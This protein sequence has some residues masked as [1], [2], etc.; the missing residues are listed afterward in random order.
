M[1]ARRKSGDLPIVIEGVALEVV[2]AKRGR[3]D[4]LQKGNA[5]QSTLRATAGALQQ[6][7]AGSVES[8]KVQSNDRS[9]GATQGYGEVIL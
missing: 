5:L 1:A 8:K 9:R 3:K 2:T 4:L 6:S 7:M